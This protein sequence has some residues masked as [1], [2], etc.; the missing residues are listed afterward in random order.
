MSAQAVA[1]AAIDANHD[2]V[3]TQAEFAAATAPVVY[4]QPTYVTSAAPVYSSAPVQYITSASELP[5]APIVYKTAPQT[6]STSAPVAYS[7]PA[8]VTYSTM[9]P[10]AA[11]SSPVTYLAPA[12]DTYA[13]GQRITYTSITTGQT[14]PGSV[15]DMYT[16]G[17][18]QVKLDIDGGVKDVDPDQ[19]FRVKP[20]AASADTTPAAVAVT[21][22]AKK[23]KVSKKSKGCC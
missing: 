19:M 15:V 1:F 2:G 13:P 8:P 14:F 23:S 20:E 12:M 11:Y 18:C 3:I 9:M 5:E 17:G 16:D 22:K 6:Y 4:A 21:K 10:A 7:T